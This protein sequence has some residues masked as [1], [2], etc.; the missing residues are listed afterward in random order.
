MPGKLGPLFQLNGMLAPF[1]EG[2]LFQL[3]GM[4]MPLFQGLL[5]PHEGPLFQLNGM[6][7]PAPHDGPLPMLKPLPGP[8]P[9]DWLLP[10]FILG[11]MSKLSKPQPPALALPAMPAKRMLTIIFFMESLLVCFVM[12]IRKQAG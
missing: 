4:V 10:Q 3:K 1:H 7:E 12:L 2:P 8:L 11:F 5:L 6:F 9:H